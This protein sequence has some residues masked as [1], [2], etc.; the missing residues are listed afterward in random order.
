MFW[1]YLDLTIVTTS[2]VELIFD[3][4]LIFE[5][6]IRSAGRA[7]DRLPRATAGPRFFLNLRNDFGGP[8][9]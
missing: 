1:N 8:F 4:V 9:N 5:E 6:D 3:I 2:V 7:P